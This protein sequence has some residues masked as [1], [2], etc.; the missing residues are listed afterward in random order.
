VP[1]CGATPLPVSVEYCSDG[2]CG[3][4]GINAYATSDGSGPR[5]NAGDIWLFGATSSP[6]GQVPMAVGVVDPWASYDTVFGALPPG[7][8]SIRILAETY[9]GPGGGPAVPSY[10][11]SICVG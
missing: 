7:T 4:I 3:F 2:G 10:F 5:L 8:S 11:R 1:W 6:F 9:T